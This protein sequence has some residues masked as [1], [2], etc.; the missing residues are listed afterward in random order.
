MAE[1]AEIEERI[2][3]TAANT[4]SLII[5]LNTLSDRIDTAN[6]NENRELA[7]YYGRA[8]TEAS[9]EF[10]DGV[11]SILDDWY[12]LKGE[13]RPPADREY[14]APETLDGIHGAVVSIVQGLPYV[15]PEPAGPVPEIDA[16]QGVNIL[17]S[18]SSDEGPAHKFDVK[19]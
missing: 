13:S 17:R 14:L 11:E 18:P 12:A 2:R 8:F 5:K 16:A 6:A 9:V 7:E 4:D 10:M 1:I 3:R 15:L 19:G